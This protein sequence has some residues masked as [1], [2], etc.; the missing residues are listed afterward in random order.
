MNE[1]AR[2]QPSTWKGSTGKH[3]ASAQE[4]R[5]RGRAGSMA[6]LMKRVRPTV[7]YAPQVEQDI[8]WWRQS[9]RAFVASLE[10]MKFTVGGVGPSLWSVQWRVKGL[11]TAENWGFRRHDPYRLSIFESKSY[12]WMIQQYCVPIQ[13]IIWPNLHK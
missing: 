10:S 7:T 11:Y 13:S 2:A 9:G 3:T 1:G 5:M 4:A 12:Y 6:L 8:G